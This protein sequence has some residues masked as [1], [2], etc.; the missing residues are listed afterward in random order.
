MPKSKLCSSTRKL[1]SSMIPCGREARVIGSPVD[2]E[3][4]YLDAINTMLSHYCR[5]QKSSNR[6]LFENPLDWLQLL[7]TNKALSALIKEDQGI[8]SFFHDFVQSNKLM[9]YKYEMNQLL[10]S[11]LSGSWALTLSEIPNINLKIR[12]G[13]YLLSLLMGAIHL[14]RLYSEGAYQKN[15]TGKAVNRVTK[16][17]NYLLVVSP[18]LSITLFLILM[19]VVYWISNASL[20]EFGANN[21]QEIN[22]LTSRVRDKINATTTSDLSQPGYEG[23]MRNVIF[24]SMANQPIE[25]FVPSPA[26]QPQQPGL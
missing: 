16:E 25:P 20:R 26:N 22:Q 7:M 13:S 10:D 24:R 12:L 6:F 3:S 17:I 15:N 8:Q 11:R 19:G 21:S 23:Y 18:Q 5:G 1:I 14:S 2:L 9:A 4:S